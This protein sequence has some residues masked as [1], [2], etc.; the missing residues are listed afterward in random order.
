LYLLWE[1]RDLF[2]NNQQAGHSDS[3]TLHQPSTILIGC[4]VYSSTNSDWPKSWVRHMTDW[5]WQVPAEVPRQWCPLRR[6]PGSGR[7]KIRPSLP[8]GGW[9]TPPP[10]LQ[11]PATCLKDSVSF[12]GKVRKYSCFFTEWHPKNRLRAVTS[13]MRSYYTILVI[14]YEDDMLP[15]LQR[16]FLKILCLADTVISCRW[17]RTDFADAEDPLILSSLADPYC[18]KVVFSSF[19]NKRR[20]KVCLIILCTGKAH[21]AAP[22]GPFMKVFTF[23]ETP[24]FYRICCLR[25]S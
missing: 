9:R 4:S 16:I 13:N 19:R 22:D 3:L 2:S 12:T 25:Q 21:L 7:A 11:P 24:P 14:F 8:A 20:R 18:P 17:P 10:P 15:F 5:L 1:G 6:L 23:L